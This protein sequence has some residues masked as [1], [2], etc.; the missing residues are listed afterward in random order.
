MQVT[1]AIYDNYKI[2][3]MNKYRLKEIAAIRNI[4]LGNLIQDVCGVS[5][6]TS[7]IWV[8]IPINSSQS[9]PSDHLRAISKA[10]H[11]SMEDLYTK[12]EEAA[13]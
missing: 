10:L 1:F 9:I 11:V 12:E 8:N 7:S 13:A 4:V 5:Q 6:R 3:G 2:C